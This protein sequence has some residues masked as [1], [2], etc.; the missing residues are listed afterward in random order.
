MKA[1]CVEFEKPATAAATTAEGSESSQASSDKVLQLMQ[2]LQQY[3]QPPDDLAGDNVRFL[4]FFLTS[5]RTS[6]SGQVPCQS[7]LWI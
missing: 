7:Q 2:Q 4:S 1:I 6:N 3:G 5:L